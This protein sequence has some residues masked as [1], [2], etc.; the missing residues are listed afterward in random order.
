MFSEQARTLFLSFQ[1]EDKRN[2]KE[3]FMEHEHLNS[4]KK[5]LEIK[6]IFDSIDLN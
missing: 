4:D 6:D 3:Y 1:F 5:I 2:F